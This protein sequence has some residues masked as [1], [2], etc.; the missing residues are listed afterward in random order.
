MCLVLLDDDSLVD[1]EKYRCCWHQHCCGQDDA[2]ADSKNVLDLLL[3]CNN[4]GDD[5]RCSCKL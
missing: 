4:I 2:T 3:H 5:D 1:S